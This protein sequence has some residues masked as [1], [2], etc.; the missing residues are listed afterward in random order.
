MFYGRLAKLWTRPL[1]ANLTVALLVGQTFLLLHWH[2]GG[3]GENSLWSLDLNEWERKLPTDRRIAPACNN[4]SSNFAAAITKHEAVPKEGNDSNSQGENSTGIGILTELE[5]TYMYGLLKQVTALFDSK[6]YSV[7]FHWRN[8]DWCTTQ[9]A[10][11][12]Q[13]VG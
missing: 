13:S 5:V 1:V 11:R 7:F 3:T 9:S 12:N 2:Q 6:Q 4:N 8:T 10:S